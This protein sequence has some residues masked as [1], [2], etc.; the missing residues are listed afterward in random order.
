MRMKHSF[1]LIAA[2]SLPLAASPAFANLI[3][4]GGFELDGSGNPSTGSLDPGSF[5]GWTPSTTNF[6]LVAQADVGNGLI[7]PATSNG[8]YVH[9]GSWAAQLGTVGLESLSQQF[10]AVVGDTYTLTYWLNG[11]PLSTTNEFD[12]HFGQAPVSAQT[13]VTTFWTENTLSFTATQALQ[14]LTFNFDDENGNFLSLDD[15]DV[16]DTTTLGIGTTGA[17][18][19]GVTPEPSSLL[20]LGT[21]ICSLAVMTRRKLF[22]T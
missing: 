12:T 21:G 14:T 15:V 6:L 2:L 18:G 5:F 22:T 4:N 20:L 11:D 10:T 9:S 3:T 1:M 17:G 8:Y 7:A 16:E 13:D 19:T